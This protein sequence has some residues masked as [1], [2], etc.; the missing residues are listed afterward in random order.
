MYII[1]MVGFRVL[2]SFMLDL[3]EIDKRSVFRGPVRK[4]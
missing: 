3:Q 2:G 1:I 4:Y